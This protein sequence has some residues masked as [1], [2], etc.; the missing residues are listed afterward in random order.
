MSGTPIPPWCAS[1]LLEALCDEQDERLLAAFRTA[2][3]SAALNAAVAVAA[4]TTPR[5]EGRTEEGTEEGTEVALERAE[6]YYTPRERRR[7]GAPSALGPRGLERVERAR[8]EYYLQ[9]LYD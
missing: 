2:G 8:G 5:D 9:S 3:K 6:G 4:G 7:V 1:R